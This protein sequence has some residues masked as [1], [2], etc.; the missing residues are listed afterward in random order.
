[1]PA[2]NET[3]GWSASDHLLTVIVAAAVIWVA[4]DGGGH[5]LP[6]RATLAIAVFWGIVVGLGFGVLSLAGLPRGTAIV[7]GLIAA[8]A[9]WTLVSIFRSPSA[10]G[11]FNEFNRVSLY[12]GVYVLVV[13][14]STR[15]TIGRWADALALAIVAVAVLALVSRLFPGS[16]SDRGLAAFLPSAA[17]RLSF[18]LGYWNG[19]GVFVGLGVPLLLRIALVGRGTWVRGLAV[20]PLPAMASVLYLTSSRG[21]F[22]T[23]IVGI[24]VFVALTERRWSAAGAAAVASAASALAIVALLDRQELVNGPLGTELV[25]EQGRSAALLV[26]LACAMSGVAY[27]AGVRLLGP[28]IQLGRTIDRIAVAAAVV[29]LAAGIVAS[30]PAQRLETFKQTPQQ[31][32]LDGGSDFVRTHLLSGSGSGRWQF[33]SAAIDQWR[34]HPLLGEGAGSYEAWW[35]EHASFSYFVRDAH[36]LYFE[37]LGELGIIGFVLVVALVLAGIGVGARRAL[38]ASGQMRVTIAALASVFC[39]FAFAAGVDWVWELAAVSV[40]ALAALALITGPSTVPLEPVRV[41]RP[42]ESPDWNLR[43][44]VLFG[45]AVGV[46]AWILLCAQAIPLLADREVAR[47]QDAVARGDLAEAADSAETARRIQPWAATPNLQLALVSEEAG[48]LDRARTWIDRAIERN[49][50]DWRLWLVSA[51]I[52]T[53]LGQVAAAERSLR[54]AAELNPRSPLFQGLLDP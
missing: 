43:R 19:L 33:W 4:Y 15:R 18:P 34:E 46:T 3:R 30:D 45:V 26:G 9:L 50:R 22:A 51:R 10:E 37:V 54:R 17:T 49:G 11:A 12:F 20:A 32:G 52:E 23:A 53:K 38:S 47:S 48:D 36:S 7:G 6:S 29:A 13:L 21:G 31:A 2:A 25:R 27:A 8:L 44:R 35:A 16:F 41:A 42:G 1:M 28:R 5:A 14:A 40:V 24:V 39:A